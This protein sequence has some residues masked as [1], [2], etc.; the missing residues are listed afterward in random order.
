MHILPNYIQLLPTFS[1]EMIM[2]MHKFIKY[3]EKFGW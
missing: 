1:V 3:H 2:A